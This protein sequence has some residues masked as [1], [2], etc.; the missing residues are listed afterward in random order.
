MARSETVGEY[1]ER[2]PKLTP[3][4]RRCKLPLLDSDAYCPRCNG[5]GWKALLRP[6][7]RKP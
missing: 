1:V 5:A 4:C 6:G 7:V 3:P 2:H